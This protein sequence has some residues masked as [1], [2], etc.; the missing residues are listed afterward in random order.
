[1]AAMT[2]PARSYAE[3]VA[4][5]AATAWV[6][7]AQLPVL[8][9]AS[10]ALLFLLPVLLA[11]TRGGLGPGLVAAGSG[12]AA[13][14]FFL[15]EPRYTFQV[16]Q[17]ENLVSLVVLAAVALVTSRLASRLM[18]REAEAQERAARSAEI[19][20]LSAVLG[21][22]PAQAALARGIGLIEARHG[23]LR[24]FPAAELPQPDGGVSALDAAA[25]AWAAHNGDCTGHGTTVM[26]AA[27]WSFLP[28]AAKNRPDIAIAAIAR[29]MD[30]RVRSEAELAHLRQ[31]ALLFGQSLD[32]DALEA[33]R[34]ERALLEERDRL[35]RTVLA[36][37]AHDFRTP[38][39]VISGQLAELAP[40]HPA[41]ADAL[42]AARRLDRMMTDLIGAARLEAGA[43]APRLEG[44]DPL[45]SINAA[46][47]TVAVP[48]GL[49]LV[50]QVPADLPFITADPVL[51]QHM[52]AN[53]ID[54]GLRH[55][56]AVVSLSTSVGDGALCLHVDDDGPGVAAA[57]RSRIFER[58]V[59]SEGTD[60]SHGSGLGLAIVKG[61]GDAMAMAITVDTAPAGGARFTLAMPLAA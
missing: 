2:S 41:A 37:L 28:M 4:A 6:A 21:G 31:I 39:T 40:A 29:P 55:A 57:D 30:G 27:D 3:A 1:M 26:A 58:F 50:R 16:H 25:A 46:A 11:A 19:A 35:R 15:L 51:L 24:L 59:R 52:I 47:D 14:N 10:A 38:L 45:D 56:R 9:L 44:V 20:E 23:T 48:A 36:S 54:N 8:G 22:H 13:Y 33:E 42:A 18:Q 12:A 43:L 7:D 5:V 60:H 32:R 17:T 49:R 61:F 53:L 34:R